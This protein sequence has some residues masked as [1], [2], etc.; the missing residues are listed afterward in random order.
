MLKV[1]LSLTNQAIG[2]HFCLSI[3]SSLRNTFGLIGISFSY[4]TKYCD[5]AFILGKNLILDSNM[6]GLLY[7][8]INTN[9]EKYHC[10]ILNNKVMNLQF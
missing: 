4:Q 7:L 5:L 8:S 1:F 3:V 9:F 2:Q 6:L 10:F